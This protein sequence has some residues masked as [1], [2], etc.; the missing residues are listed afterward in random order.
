M[1]IIESASHFDWQLPEVFAG[2]DATETP[3]PIAYPTAAR[4]QAWAAGTPVLLLQILLGLQPDWRRHTLESVAPLE[5][6]S[7]VGTLKLTGVRAFERTWDAEVEDGAV[8]VVER[9]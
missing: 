4:P 2:F 1:R 6:P 9:K 3:F 7:W 8:S 5:L